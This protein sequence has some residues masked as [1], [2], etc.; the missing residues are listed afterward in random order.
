[1][2]SNAAMD[3][4]VREAGLVVLSEEDARSAEGGLLW[5]VVI[6]GLAL[7]GCGDYFIAGGTQHT[8]SPDLM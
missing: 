8:P 1:M 3:R 4:C 5:L 2:K 6:A 7:A